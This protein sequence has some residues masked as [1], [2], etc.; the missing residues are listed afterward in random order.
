MSTERKSLML[1]DDE[2]AQISK[3]AKAAGV[4]RPQ[5]IEAMIALTDQAR[6]VAKLQEIR[7]NAA[8]EKAEEAKKRSKLAEL[9]SGL[10]L[11]QIEALLKQ[12]Q[13]S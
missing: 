1:G 7:A 13:A 10:D 2:Y 6:L 9:A 4:P 3:I 12:F 11:T 5:V 8:L